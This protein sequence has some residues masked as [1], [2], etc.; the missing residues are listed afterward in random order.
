M[1]DISRLT[2]KQ[3]L[4]LDCV[5][6]GTSDGD[7]ID[8]DQLLDVLPYETSKQSMQFSIRALIGR[9]LVE[10]KET[11]L[12]R[13]RRRVIYSLSRTGYSMFGSEDPSI[14]LLE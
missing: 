4:I 5:K 10:K 7:F 3:F 8:M 6:R 1:M 13:G 11:E 2:R 14:I 9:G 12:R